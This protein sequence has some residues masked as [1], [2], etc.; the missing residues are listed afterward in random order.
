MRFN[1]L[2]L[3]FSKIKNLINKVVLKKLSQEEILYSNDL[4]LIQINSKIKD[5]Q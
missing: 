2:T 1:F 5:N 4:L 3:V